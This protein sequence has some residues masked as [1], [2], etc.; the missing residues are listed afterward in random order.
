MKLGPFQS[1]GGPS[2][3][4]LRDCKTLRNLRDG[5]FE[6]LSLD[7]HVLTSP[8]CRPAGTWPPP[9]PPPRTSRPSPTPTQAQPGEARL[10]QLRHPN[11]FIYL[12][13]NYRYA[14]SGILLARFL[15]FT[16]I[17]RKERVCNMWICG[18][19]LFLNY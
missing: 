18:Y 15:Y 3:G 5:S 1:G 2:R 9:P 4:L 8:F 14:I 13:A 19:D 6:A 7:E 17:S 12:N 11:H 10:H 16:L